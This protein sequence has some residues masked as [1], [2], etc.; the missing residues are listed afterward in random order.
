M[1]VELFESETRE[2]TQILSICKSSN[3]IY[4]GI[5]TGKKLIK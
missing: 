1:L 4:V 5:I 2:P 3:E